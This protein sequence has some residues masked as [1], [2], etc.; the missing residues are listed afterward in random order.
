MNYFSGHPKM[1][2]F[3]THAGL[4]GSSE[5]AFC[6]VPVVATPM[7]GDQYLNAAALHNRGMG[8]VLPYE[9]I[10]KE[11][12]FSSLRK[13]L[14]IRSAEN[15]KRVSFSYK[16]RPLTPS[17]AAVWYSEYVISTNG[18]ILTKSNSVI[19]NWFAYHSLDVYLAIFSV[20]LR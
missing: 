2:V 5:A 16:N 6:G 11:S 12:V 9:K 15:A 14:D 10:T 8:V 20:L 17:E 7:Y 19:M 1:R 4:L 18:A 3:M 13:A